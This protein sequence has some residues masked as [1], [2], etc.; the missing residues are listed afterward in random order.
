MDD[1]WAGYPQRKDFPLTYEAPEFSHN[2]DNI[3]LDDK[4]PGWEVN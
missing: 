3:A 2:R 4:T 1:D